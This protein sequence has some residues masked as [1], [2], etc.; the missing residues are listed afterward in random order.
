[1]WIGERSIEAVDTCAEEELA[2]R[3][4]GETRYDVLYVRELV[5]SA[6]LK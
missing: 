1:M 5:S 6:P 4:K 3:I 2:R